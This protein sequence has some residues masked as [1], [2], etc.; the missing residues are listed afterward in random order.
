MISGKQVAKVMKNIAHLLFGLSII[1]QRNLIRIIMKELTECAISRAEEK[2]KTILEKEV[3][4]LFSE[5]WLP[6]HDLSHHKRVWLFTKE[7][8]VAFDKQDFEFIEASMIAAYMHDTGLSV[9]LSPEHGQI[10]SSLTKNLL[11]KYPL[12][13]PFN[14]KELLEAVEKHDDKSYSNIKTEQSS[15][16][17]Y[18]VLTIADDLDAFGA[19]GLYRYFEIYALRK[20][21]TDEIVQAIDK[22][23]RKRYEFVSSNLTRFNAI[24]EKQKKQLNIA[25]YF[26]HSFTLREVD[27][28][29]EN[30][31]AKKGINEYLNDSFNKFPILR[32]LLMEIVEE[33]TISRY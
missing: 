9:T 5:I 4:T 22:N 18:E 31:I 13:N 24:L 21:P 26:L 6:S 15:P 17:L 1:I 14:K 29:I 30:I 11:D 10:S 8:L 33:E 23:I 7:L 2:W 25:L 32:K 20:M 16:G 27:Y 3:A 19:L 28:M 12:E